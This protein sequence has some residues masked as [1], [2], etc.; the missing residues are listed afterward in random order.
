MFS[1]LMKFTFYISLWLTSC[2]QLALAEE[3][4]TFDNWLATLDDDTCWIATHPDLA[5]GS[6]VEFLETELYFS[7]A[8]HKGSTRPEIS[9]QS[10]LLKN[11]LK[12]ITHDFA[13]ELYG[14]VTLLED[15]AFTEGNDDVE[16]IKH[17]VKQKPNLI[18][19][20][21]SNAKRPVHL[22]VSYTGFQDAYNFISKNCTLDKATGAARGTG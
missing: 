1:N 3:N 7:I 15:T 5:E 12:S 14:F 10:N 11:D 20:I 13:G 22:K 16:I 19:L 2:T 8:L 9:Y 17:M 21:F 18:T 4:F 6:I